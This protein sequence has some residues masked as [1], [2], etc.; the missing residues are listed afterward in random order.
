MDDFDLGAM[1][2]SF[3]GNLHE[4]RERRLGFFWASDL[5]RCRRQL[6]YTFIAPLEHRP[7]TS[8]AYMVGTILHEFLQ[9]VM[10]ADVGTYKTVTPEKHVSVVDAATGMT[11]S[12]RMDAHIV[13]KSG[14]PFVVELKSVNE[15]T[16]NL[17]KKPDFA[18]IN[19]LNF[20]MHA[21][22][23]KSGFIVYVNKTNLALRVHRVVY[24]GPLMRSGL[25]SLRQTMGD[26]R[27]SRLPPRDDR[28]GWKC[29]Y[30]PWNAMCLRNDNPALRNRLFP[31]RKEA[32]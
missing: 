13:P 3:V 25:S 23:L 12:G 31:D 15:R 14:E 28:S 4:K 16:F 32:A 2:D 27:Q 8:R 18:H 7:A 29:D 17:G 5:G 19:Q 1:L 22:Y 21:E 24:S 30:C 10:L 11:V 6:Y 26:I 20:Y 9:K